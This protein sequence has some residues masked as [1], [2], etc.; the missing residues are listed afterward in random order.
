M[1]SPLSVTPE[2]TSGQKRGERVPEP[3]PE[4]SCAHCSAANCIKL[5]KT[6]PDFCV[7][8]KADEAVKKRCT[9]RYLKSSKDRKIALAAADIAGNYY[10]ITTRVEEILLFVKKMGYERVGV[11]SCVALLGA[12][13]QFARIAHAKGVHVYGVACK[14]GAVDKNEIGAGK[15]QEPEPGAHESMCN[16]ILQAELLNEAQTDFNIIMGLCVGHDTLFIEHSRAPVTYLIVKDRVL[17]NNPAAAL[18]ETSGFYKRLLTP[19]LP[20][21]NGTNSR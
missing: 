21:P 19:D 16:P 15:R 14:V 6:F 7:T 4:M 18:Y 5:T 17:C 20:A 1:K 13:N 12:C 2:K 8:V 11:A 9:Q 10:G 3:L